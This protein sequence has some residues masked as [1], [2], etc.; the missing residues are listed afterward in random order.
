MINSLSNSKGAQEQNTNRPQ[1]AYIRIERLPIA[2]ERHGKVDPNFC[3][4]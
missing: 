2:C 4:A 3:Y 1:L